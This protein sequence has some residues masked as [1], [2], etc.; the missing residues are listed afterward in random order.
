MARETTARCRAQWDDLTRQAD[1]MKPFFGE[2]HERARQ[3]GILP[4]VMRELFAR[5]GF[6]EIAAAAVR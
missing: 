5:Y 4:G 1:R 2:I 6:E 3:A